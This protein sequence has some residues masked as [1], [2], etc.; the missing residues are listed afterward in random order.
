MSFHLPL[1]NIPNGCC[2]GKLNHVGINSTY[3]E[4]MALHHCIKQV[5]W[6]RQLIMELGLI[7]WVNEP[8]RILADNKQANNLASEDVVTAG[9]MYFRTGY[10]YNKEAVED[11]FV[12]VDYVTTHD[13]VADATTKA[14]AGVKVKAFQPILHGLKPPLIH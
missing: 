7:D 3:N 5:V 4:Y 9:N 8:T 1:F 10:H 14:L 6:L 11:G 2:T 13:N 12:R